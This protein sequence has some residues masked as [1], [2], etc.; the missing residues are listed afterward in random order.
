[1]IWTI[2]KVRIEFVFQTKCGKKSGVQW[3]DQVIVLHWDSCFDL[4][5]RGRVMQICVRNLTIIGSDN[6]LA[7]GRR[8]AIIWT[9]AGLLLIE[10]LRTNLI[11]ILCEILQFSFKKIRLNVLFE[12]WLPFCLCLN[13]LTCWQGLQMSYGSMNLDQHWFS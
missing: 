13:V 1:M 5:H 10:P 12:K 4:T 2:L 9:K 3:N 6:S 7:P 11:E 8:Q